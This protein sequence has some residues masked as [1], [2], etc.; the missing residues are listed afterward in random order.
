[1][2]LKF[3]SPVFSTNEAI[4]APMSL[5]MARMAVKKNSF[6]SS[7]RDPRTQLWYASRHDAQSEE[8]ERFQ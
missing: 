6:T 4:G 2:H 7:L 5:P 3:T 8:Y 1:M